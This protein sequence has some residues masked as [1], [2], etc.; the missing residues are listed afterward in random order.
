VVA[1]QPL[2]IS[3]AGPQD[4]A[5]RGSDHFFENRISVCDFEELVNRIAGVSAFLRRVRYFD[6]YELVDVFIGEW[7]KDYGVEH[8]VDRGRCYDAGGER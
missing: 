5:D 3:V 2:R 6:V 4:V 7:I 8:V 1:A